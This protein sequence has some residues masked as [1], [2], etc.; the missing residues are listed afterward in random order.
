MNSDFT[1]TTPLCQSYGMYGSVNLCD[2]ADRQTAGLDFKTWKS[3]LKLECRSS[4]YF[5][6][7]R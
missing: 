6:Y 2:L 5:H 4:R 3:L 7:L 1:H